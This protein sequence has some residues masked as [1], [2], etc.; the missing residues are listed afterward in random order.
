MI[1]FASKLYPAHVVQYM[2][3]AGSWQEIFMQI[4]VGLQ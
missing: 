4:K 2:K 3:R 1:M